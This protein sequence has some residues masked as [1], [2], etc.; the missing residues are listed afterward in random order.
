[1]RREVSGPGVDE[2]LVPV[3]GLVVVDNNIPVMARL[4]QTA[5]MVVVNN[6]TLMMTRRKDLRRME[7]KRRKR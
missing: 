7:M 1:M 3:M 6:N 4:K 5:A 2:I